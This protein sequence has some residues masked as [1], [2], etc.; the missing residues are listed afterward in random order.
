MCNKCWCKKWTLQMLI[1]QYLISVLQLYPIYTVSLNTVF[2]I[3]QNQ[4]DMGT[5]CSKTFGCWVFTYG[6]TV[7]KIWAWSDIRSS[8]AETSA[9]KWTW[10]TWPDSKRPKNWSGRVQIGFIKYIRVKCV[11]VFLK[12]TL[13]D[14]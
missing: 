14:I 10:P 11:T 8:W 1:P 3:P 13:Y 4:C 9:A 5:T 12:Q 2:L 7:L 6:M